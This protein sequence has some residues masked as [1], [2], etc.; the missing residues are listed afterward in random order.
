MVCSLKGAHL[1]KLTETNLPGIE[2]LRNWR[3]FVFLDFTVYA[4]SV[5]SILAG[6]RV[7]IGKSGQDCDF[8]LILNKAH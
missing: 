7:G 1:H 4:F 3:E 6:M 8:S 2:A 5:F